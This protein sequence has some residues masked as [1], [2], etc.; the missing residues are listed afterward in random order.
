MNQEEILK[1]A[2]LTRG[3][4]EIFRI[5]QE[6]M[7]NEIAIA[8]PPMSFPVDALYGG[9]IDIQGD[10]IQLKEVLASDVPEVELLQSSINSLDPIIKVLSCEDDEGFISDDVVC[11]M[12]FID[13]E[14]LQMK[15]MIILE[16]AYRA[17][18]SLCRSIKAGIA[19][20]NTEK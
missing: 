19:E 17:I 4:I 1:N 7:F 16:Q 8:L 6:D 3:A 11:H 5:M 20:I 2:Y 15:I 10:I 13:W 12:D 14:R 9:L 18:E